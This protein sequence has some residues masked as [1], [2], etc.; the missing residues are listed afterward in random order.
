MLGGRVRQSSVDLNRL[1]NNSESFSANEGRQGVEHDELQPDGRPIEAVGF[2]HRVHLQSFG[3]KDIIDLGDITTSRETFRP[4][5]VPKGPPSNTG[6][7]RA[8]ECI[9]HQKSE[10]RC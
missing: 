6:H 4:I 7:L 8:A 2:S 5:F 9:E 1:A 3:W 10:S